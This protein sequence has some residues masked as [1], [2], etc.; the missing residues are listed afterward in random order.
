[1]GFFKLLMDKAEEKMKPKDKPFTDQG[2]THHIITLRTNQMVI[3]KNVLNLEEIATETMG[4]IAN[5]PT[6]DFCFSD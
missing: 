6:I 1:M 5:N 4:V 3:K 2:F